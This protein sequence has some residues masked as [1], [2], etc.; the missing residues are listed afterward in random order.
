MKS[1][2]IGIVGALIILVA[3][4]AGCTSN[5]NTNDT[6][7]KILAN[8][9]PIAEKWFEANKPDVKDISV[10]LDKKREFYGVVAGS[11][12]KD[13][14]KYW[15]WLNVDTEEF[16][17]EEYY[18]LL[19]QYIQERL[20]DG[21][22]I[23]CKEID[24]PVEAAVIHGK[25][26]YSTSCP[27]TYYR[28]ST[29]EIADIADKEM[30]KGDKEIRII[31][32]APDKMIADITVLDILKEHSNWTFVLQEDREALEYRVYYSDGK[33]HIAR[34]FYDDKGILRYENTTLEALE[35][36]VD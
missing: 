27:W 18:E 24:I 30:S 14:K 34:A 4:L 5:G 20:L 21:L 26:G 2:I 33:Y 28:F 9:K 12:Y 3:L 10:E 15:Y 22:G 29:N 13:S 25:D 16:C 19:V 31:V 11:Y 1:N 8:V 7:E 32:P 17:S 36:E 35:K 23:E 6:Q